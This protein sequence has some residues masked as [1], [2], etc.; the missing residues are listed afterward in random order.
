LNSSAVHFFTTRLPMRSVNG[1]A[2][3]HLT[4]SLYFLPAE[5]SDA[6]TACSSKCGC[7]ASRRMKRWPTE[8]VAPSTPAIVS[9]HYKPRALL[10]IPHFFLGN[11][12]V[13]EVK[14]SAS[15]V[16]VADVQY[17]ESIGPLSFRYDAGGEE[18]RPI[19]EV[20]RLLTH[21][22]SQQALRGARMQ[23]VLNSNESIHDRRKVSLYMSPANACSKDRHPPNAI[24]IQHRGS[25]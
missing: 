5:R 15:M 10:Y 25:I 20:R 22:Q 17:S 14:C 23:R 21:H 8:P 9:A 6:P 19:T 11:S 24:L 4:A 12:G 16:V 2:C 1:I 18:T 7:S 13:L 3:F